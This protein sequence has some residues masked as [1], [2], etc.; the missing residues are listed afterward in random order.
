MMLA[1]S[2]SKGTILDGH[3]DAGPTRP[4][5]GS[6]ILATLSEKRPARFEPCVRS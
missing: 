1:V 6:S 5:T 4:E 3:E 2:H